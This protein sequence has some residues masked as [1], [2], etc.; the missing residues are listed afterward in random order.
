VASSIDA[1]NFVE[2][3]SMYNDTHTC[4]HTH[5]QHK[6]AMDLVAQEKQAAV[7]LSESAAAKMQ[8][9]ERS[10]HALAEKEHELRLLVEASEAQVSGTLPRTS[11]ILF[12]T[13]SFCTIQQARDAHK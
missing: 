5:T 2:F 9:V 12:G 13:I 6:R 4:V 10:M 8:C 11:H 7:A 3:K 1:R